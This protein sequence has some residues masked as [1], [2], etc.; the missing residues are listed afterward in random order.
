MDQDNHRP[1]IRE[2][3][4]FLFDHGGLKAIFDHAKNIV[5]ATLIMAAG[6]SVMKLSGMTAIT[7]LGLP[8]FAGT[9]VALVGF[10]LLALNF[11]DGWRAMREMKHHLALHIIMLM[12]YALLS[13]RI[14]Q[15]VFQFRSL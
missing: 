5:V 13:W 10:S 7:F 12:S 4:T 9:G 6:T 8:T 2:I 15:I 1:V 3:A 11:I 14:A